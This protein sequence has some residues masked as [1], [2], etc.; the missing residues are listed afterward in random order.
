MFPVHVK[1]YRH[2]VWCRQLAWLY[3]QCFKFDD[4]I[5]CAAGFDSMLDGY[6]SP[7]MRIRL[8]VVVL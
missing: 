7:C 1:K 6:P 4:R 2:L 3:M 5:L 8:D